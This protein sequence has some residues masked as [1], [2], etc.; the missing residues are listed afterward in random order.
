MFLG[1][2]PHH[3]S[4]CFH[5]H[6]D[7]PSYVSVSVSL[8]LSL[9]LKHFIYLFSERGGVRDKERAR[10]S[11]CERNID[12][13]PLA[14]SQLG[15]QPATH[16]CPGQESNQWPFWFA[17]WRSIH[18][19]TSARAFSLFFN[20]RPRTC[21]MTLERGGRRERERERGTELREKHWLVASRTALTG[22]RTCN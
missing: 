20:P 15:T 7:S 19:A 9:F 10:N 1:L 22:D 16:T 21:L 13:L 2:W 5:P 11:M 14:H 8:L 18:G 12:Q 17:V 3:W 6:M 4:L